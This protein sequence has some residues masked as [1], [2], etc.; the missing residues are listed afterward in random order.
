M[1][2]MFEN[3]TDTQLRSMTGPFQF[4]D[5]DVIIRAR[6]GDVD[7]DFPAHKLILS[8]ASSMFNDMFSIPCSHTTSEEGNPTIEVAEDAQTIHDILSW[9]YSYGDNVPF[10]DFPTLHRLVLGMRKYSMP[11]LRVILAETLR[12]KAVEDPLRVFAIACHA[13][14]PRIAQIVATH[15][16]KW[17]F[18]AIGTSNIPE[19]N[20]LRARTMCKLLRYHQEC[21]RVAS[22]TILRRADSYPI[23]FRVSAF[24]PNSRGSTDCTRWW[25]DYVNRAA[26]QSKT[27]PIHF[28][29]TSTKIIAAYCLSAEGS[30]ECSRSVALKLIEFGECVEQEVLSAVGQVE[31]GMD[32]DDF[33]L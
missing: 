28:D 22:E 18:V 5:A 10:D 21:G 26:E 25:K 27:R 33:L 7:V 23:S 14:L 8:H 17:E 24:Q 16:L 9:I 1:T 2:S 12:A 29:Y 13:E 30:A 15:V 4:D 31:L 20:Q 6:L 11:N 32:D 19:F 3:L